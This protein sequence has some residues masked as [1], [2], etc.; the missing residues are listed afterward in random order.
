MRAKHTVLPAIAM[1]AILALPLHAQRTAISPYVGFGAPVGSFISGPSGP[2]EILFEADFGTALGLQFDLA[3]SK[4]LSLGVVGE[5]GLDQGMELTYNCQACGFVEPASMRV[6]RIHG[7]MG[8]RPFG[9]R[10]DGRPTPL[11]LEV[12]AGITS[13]SFDYENP[14]IDDDRS[15]GSVQSAFAGIAFDIPLGPRRT[16]IRFFG[17]G[18]VA[19]KLEADAVDDLSQLVGTVTAEPVITPQLGVA[20][21]LGL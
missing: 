2:S 5:Y 6:M 8:L 18:L 12:G 21:R 14:T 13:Y 16:A 20:L 1:L 9:M 4:R 15:N 19:Q 17:R 11:V 3:L 7:V 10:P